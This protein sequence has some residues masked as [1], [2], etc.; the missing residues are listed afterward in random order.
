[1]D[2]V[3]LDER[4]STIRSDEP[5]VVVSCDGHVAPPLEAYREYCPPDRLGDFDEY[6][7]YVDANRQAKS[8]LSIPTSAQGLKDLEERWINMRAPGGWEVGPR[9]R[10]MDRDGVAAEVIFHGSPGGGPLPFTPL[11]ASD[12]IEDPDLVG[13]GRRMY[14]RWLADFCSVEPERHVGLA[15]LPMWDIDAAI[16]E[17]ELAA[18]IGLKGV[19]FPGPRPEIT[20]YEDPAW[21]PFWA[22]CA[23][24]GMVLAN[25]GGGG[26]TAAPAIGPAAQFIYT[27]ESVAVSR[28]SPIN[29]LVFSGVFERHPDLMFVQT[30]QPGWWYPTVL[31]E[32]D[33]QYLAF[34]HR[35]SEW[36]PRLPSEYCRTNYFIGA[37]FQSRGEA[38]GAI[39]DGATANVMWGSDY[40]HPEGTYHYTDDLDTEPAT[41]QS[42]RHTYAGLPA[43]AT[44]A[45]LGENALRVYGYD[46]T[47]LR[48]VAERIG[49]PTL[50]ELA[51]PLDEIPPHWTLAFRQHSAYH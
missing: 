34:E 30:E 15:H 12:L 10:D 16:R 32:L 46:A 8:S 2:V 47:A 4:P 19:N 27:I 50:D 51:R 7:G 5:L 42:L 39:R 17:V 18:E 21:D 13:V 3:Q 45:M 14:N 29:R 28:V 33:S 23:E 43:D 26:V 38:E 49:A 6:V 48:Q 31:E 9:L 25:H 35:I 11:G 20:P 36:L 44:R 41:R 37:S 1:M 40:P 24:R 22:V